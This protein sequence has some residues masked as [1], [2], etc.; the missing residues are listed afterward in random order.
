MGVEINK[1][2]CYSGDTA[3]IFIGTLGRY[4]CLLNGRGNRRWRALHRAVFDADYPFIEGLENVTYR[5]IDINSLGVFD[6]LPAR[7][8]EG[9][10]LCKFA[11][12][13]R[14]IGRVY[15]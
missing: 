7:G 12:L 3:S 8:Y 2:G 1:T 13:L 14:V 9:S 5:S 15:Q 11:Y 4:K 10:A 6:G